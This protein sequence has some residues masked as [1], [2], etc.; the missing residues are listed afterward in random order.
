MPPNHPFARH[1]RRCRPSRAPGAVAAR[2]IAP[3]RDLGGGAGAALLLRRLHQSERP[4]HR[5]RLP[6]ALRRL[7]APGRA[8]D[9]GRRDRHLRGKRRRGG[10]ARVLEPD[11]AVAAQAGAASADPARGQGAALPR[12]PRAL[13]GRTARGDRLAADGARGPRGGGRGVRRRGALLLT[14]TH[15]HQARRRSYERWPRN[16][17]WLRGVA[18]ARAAS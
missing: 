14:I 11:D 10:G 15:D 18:R 6:G 13:E 4:H 8:A 5:G 9:F 16:S 3:E 17:G 2:L 1:A 7:G 12:H